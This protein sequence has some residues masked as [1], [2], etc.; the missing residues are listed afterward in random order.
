MNK[1]ISKSWQFLEDIGANIQYAGD[2]KIYVRWN[3][4]DVRDKKYRFIIT[5][6]NNTWISASLENFIKSRLND[7]VILKSNITDKG[8]TI[9]GR[10]G[11]DGKVKYGCDGRWCFK[12]HGEGI[13]WKLN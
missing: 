10:C 5:I 2:G 6:N 4:K 12:C 13:I 9:C 7:G 8:H 1:S 11:G 3:N